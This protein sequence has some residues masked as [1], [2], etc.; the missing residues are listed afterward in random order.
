MLETGKE[1]SH[2]SGG[3]S[4]LSPG[5]LGGLAGAGLSKT[6]GKNGHGAVTGAIE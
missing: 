6:R 5:V 4:Y 3:E 2:A 1:G